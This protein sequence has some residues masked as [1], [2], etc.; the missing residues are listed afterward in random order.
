MRSRHLGLI[1]GFA[2][3][4]TFLVPSARAQ[5]PTLIVADQPA[6]R[7]MTIPSV[8][9]PSPGFVVIYGSNGQGGPDEKAVLGMARVAAGDNTDIAVVLQ[10]DARPGETLYAR[11]HADT[12]EPGRFEYDVDHRDVDPPVTSA[13]SPVML[14]FLVR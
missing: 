9:S 13:G 10:R 4:G 5:T 12:G 3:V 7:H 2:L 6:G 8:M 11:L 1:A 14:P